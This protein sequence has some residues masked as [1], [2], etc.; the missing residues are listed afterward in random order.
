MVREVN[1]PFE[2]LQLAADLLA[3]VLQDVAN[4]NLHVLEIGLHV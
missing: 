3:M 2:P 4:I 1:A